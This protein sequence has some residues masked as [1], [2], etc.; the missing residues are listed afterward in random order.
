MIGE[1]INAVLVI[2]RLNLFIIWWVR[3]NTGGVDIDKPKRGKNMRHGVLKHKKKRKQKES[4]GVCLHKSSGLFLA[5]ITV[6]SKRYEL[7]YYRDMDDAINSVRRA[8]AWVSQFG[9]Q[10]FEDQ[11][12]PE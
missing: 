7:G 6:L 1:R 11:Y 5:R 2:N 12:I 10:N 3:C 8:K 9:T 4:L